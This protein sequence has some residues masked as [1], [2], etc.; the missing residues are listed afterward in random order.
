MKLTLVTTLLFLAPCALGHGYV[1]V[2]G[3]AGTSYAA[4]NG[5]EPTE[6]GHATAPSVVRRISTIDPV[7]GANNPFLNCG[8]NATAAA[9][10]A[11]TAAGDA[12]TF[13]W[14]AGGGEG[15]PHDMGPLMFY[16][17][18]CGD[19]TCDQF[20]STTAQWFKIAQI[21]LKSD[22]VTWYQAVAKSM[23]LVV[24]GGPANVTLPSNI[25]PGNYLFRHEII[26]LHL[27]NEMG[28][29]EFY[30]SCSQINITGSGTGAPTAE[31]LVSFPGAYSD[32][33][34]GIYVPDQYK[35]SKQHGKDSWHIKEQWLLPD[36][37][38]VK[39]AY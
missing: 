18:N 13:N 33:D 5:D 22:R 15:W 30:P 10:V 11:P 14:E 38:S 9:L 25:A 27:A 16:L 26:A 28:G 17:A 1:S 23:F 35:Q 36:H 32:K 8:Q 37:L 29:A 4:F 20:D 21:G 31:E 7:K 39:R 3:V 6:D 24:A 12:L 19:T 34:P 2:L